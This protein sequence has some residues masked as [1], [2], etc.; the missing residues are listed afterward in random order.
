MEPAHILLGH[1]GH[2]GRMF[3]CSNVPGVCPGVASQMGAVQRSLPAG[4]RRDGIPV[5]VLYRGSLSLREILFATAPFNCP[6][7]A[8]VLNRM[9]FV[10]LDPERDAPGMS[11]AAMDALTQD[12][13]R[14]GDHLPIIVGFH[15]QNG[16]K[17]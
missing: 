17:T 13:H 10:F 1:V 7:T 4:Y 16:E 2:S 14:L 3:L 5:I 9:G 11:P 15:P 12:I 8:R 6:E